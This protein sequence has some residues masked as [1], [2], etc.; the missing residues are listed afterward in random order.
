[1][2]HQL[3]PPSKDTNNNLSAKNFLG[4]NTS[5]SDIDFCSLISEA[6]P[7]AILVNECGE[8]EIQMNKN[9]SYF[10]AYELVF[11]SDNKDDMDQVLN[12]AENS[13]NGD[14]LCCFAETKSGSLL[15]ATQKGVIGIINL[16][17]C[18]TA[19]ISIIKLNCDSPAPNLNPN[20]DLYDIGK[21][22]LVD[23]CVDNTNEQI[24]ILTKHCAKEKAEFKIEIY[25]FNEKN[26]EMTLMR[27]L[28]L[29]QS[30][31]GSNTSQNEPSEF[32]RIYLDETE[33]CF[34]TIDANNHKVYWFNTSNC[35]AKRCVKSPDGES[36]HCP[37][38]LALLPDPKNIYI[39]SKKGMLICRPDHQSVKHDSL[40]PIDI[41]FSKEDNSLYFIDQFALYRTRITDTMA[42]EQRYKRIFSNKTQNKGFRRVI[43]CQKHIFIMSNDI[44]SLFV[45][46]REHLK[47]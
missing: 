19:W 2:S 8:I 3:S 5:S 10:Y 4:P 46:E 9:H 47:L 26:N 20:D 40:K 36:I 34:V 14:K 41:A 39:C 24:I 7:A 23:L 1:M 21:K 44:N 45:I 28:N 18:M 42:N 35:Q 27:I 12:Q 38:G 15:L 32:V 37:S 31:A 22:M 13:I 6:K 11:H 17:K 29:S 25:S 43:A 33:S 30:Q 16:N